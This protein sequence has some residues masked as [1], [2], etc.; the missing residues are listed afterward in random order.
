MLLAPRLP[1]VCA[2]KLPAVLVLLD[3]SA[4]NVVVALNVVPAKPVNHYKDHERA[5]PNRPKIAQVPQ[6]LFVN[7]IG[8]VTNSFLQINDIECCDN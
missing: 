6:D 4:V 7:T 8:K 1:L 2:A 3:V 5:S